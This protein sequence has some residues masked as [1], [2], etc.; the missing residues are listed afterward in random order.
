MTRMW[1]VE[2][3]ETARPLCEAVQFG[4]VYW[5]DAS[6]GRFA[7]VRGVAEK[8]TVAE[9]GWVPASRIWT[10]RELE[11]MPWHGP[12]TLEAVAMAFA[13]P[14]KACDCSRKVRPRA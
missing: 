5:L 11:S 6:D 1:T 8:A 13:L 12:P 7:V 10:L 9:K 14:G 4:V 2:P 3:H